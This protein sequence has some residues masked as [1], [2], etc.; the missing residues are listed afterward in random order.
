[1]VPLREVPLAEIEGKIA[2]EAVSRV[3]SSQPKQSQYLQ[4]TSAPQ[5]GGFVQGEEQHLTEQKR[6]E[7]D[8]LIRDKVLHQLGFDREG[9]EGDAY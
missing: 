1:M 8:H 6:R 5:S 2:E 4:T 9:R 3:E 7:R